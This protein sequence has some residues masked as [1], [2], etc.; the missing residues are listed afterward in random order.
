MASFQDFSTDASEKSNTQAQPPR[1][2]A[3]GCSAWLGIVIA[4]HF[5]NMLCKPILDLTMPWYRL[6]YFDS[7]SLS[8]LPSIIR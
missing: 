1:V 3:V 7:R 8:D 6:R 2:S 4:E 5:D